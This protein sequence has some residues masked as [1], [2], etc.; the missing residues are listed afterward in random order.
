[1]KDLLRSNSFPHIFMTGELQ[2]SQQQ[3]F[4]FDTNCIT[5]SIVTT[6]EISLDG[7][8]VQL[9]RV[10]NVYQSKLNTRIGE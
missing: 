5:T 10:I 2:R 9:C 6:I 3:S 7:S 8:F 4:S 1:M